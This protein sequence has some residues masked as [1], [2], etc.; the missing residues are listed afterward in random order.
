[1]FTKLKKYKFEVAKIRILGFIVNIK[2][3]T[4]ELERVK[5]ILD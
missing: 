3:S 5:T 1:M 4:I 2:G